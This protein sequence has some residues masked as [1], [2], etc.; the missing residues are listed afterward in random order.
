M[1]D[2]NLY[3]EQGEAE[4]KQFMVK[5]LLTA[6][7]ELLAPKY[8]IKQTDQIVELDHYNIAAGLTIE[9]DEGVGDEQ[10]LSQI[11]ERVLTD[12][13]ELINPLIRIWQVDD[14]EVT[15]DLLAPFTGIKMGKTNSEVDAFEETV[16]EQY[17]LSINVTGSI[18]KELITT[19]KSFGLDQEQAAA[20]TALASQMYGG[21]SDCH[22]YLISQL[23]NWDRTHPEGPSSM[24]ISTRA[25]GR[26]SDDLETPDDAVQQE[27]MEERLRQLH[28]NK[29]HWRY[30]NH[31][32]VPLDRGLFDSIWE[33]S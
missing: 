33:E 5:S 32:Q 20:L 27:L 18:F 12:H 4:D 28:A 9:S 25:Y 6:L 8:R 22:A 3:D 26:L 17:V 30:H 2:D 14:I 13:P 16:F 31:N 10:E 1:H 24:V 11:I 7:G 29:H 19:A 15:D 21:G 23:D